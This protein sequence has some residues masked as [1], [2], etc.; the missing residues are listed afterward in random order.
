MPRKTKLSV[1]TLCEEVTAYLAGRINTNEGARRLGL[2]WQSFSDWVRRYESEGI[3]GLQPKIVNKCY[4]PELKACAVRE[5]LQGEGSLQQICKRYAIRGR[6]TLRRWIKAYNCHEATR[7]ITGGSHMTQ[8]RKTTMEE[9]LKMVVECITNGKN[10]GEIALKYKVSYQQIYAWVKKYLQK[11]EGGLDDRRG[12]KL[13][14]QGFKTEEQQLRARV[15][16]LEHKLYYA[17]MENACLKKLDEVE[18]GLKHKH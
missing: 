8:G 5:Y 2:S 10:Y 6:E 9:R 16:E 11:G 15:R 14:P 17:E 13:P 1:E 3:K 18:R 4:G 12:K 7:S